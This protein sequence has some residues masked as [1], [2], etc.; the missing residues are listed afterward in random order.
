MLGMFNPETTVP[1][2]IFSDNLFKDIQHFTDRA[3]PDGVN[4][5]L[6]THVIS[7]GNDLADQRNILPLTI[8]DTGRLRAIL[9]GFQHEGCMR[10]KTSITKPF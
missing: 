2:T 4:D 8:M 3:I 1:G 7:I 5:S 10:T 6:I 9:I